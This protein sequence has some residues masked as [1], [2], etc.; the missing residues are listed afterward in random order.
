MVR[1]AHEAVVQSPKRLTTILPTYVSSK[2]IAWALYKTLEPRC[3]HNPSDCKAQTPGSL[4]WSASNVRSTI[5]DTVLSFAILLDTKTPNHGTKAERQ[6]L[7]C[8]SY[9]SLQ[10]HRSLVTSTGL[11]WISLRSSILWCPVKPWL[12]EDGVGL[13]FCG[14]EYP[15]SASLCF[16]SNTALFLP[17]CLHLA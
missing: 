3:E 5:P 17:F 13:Q 6:K 7:G 11:R 16:S 15:Q 4:V 14:S 2:L 8:L 1:P 9:F 12:L 10:E